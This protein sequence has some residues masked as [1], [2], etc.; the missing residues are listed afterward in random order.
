M[1]ITVEVPGTAEQVWDAIAT[2]NGVSAW[3]MPT[4]LEERVG[5]YVAFHMGETTSEGRI[6]A[7]DQPRRIEYE[8]P[9]WADLTGHD[10]AVVSP[11]VTEFLVEARSGGTCVVRVVSSAFG[12]GADWEREFFADMEQGWRPFFENLRL[13][14]TEFPGQQV[15]SLSVDAQIPDANGSS[16]FAALRRQI[17]ASDVGAPVEVNGVSGRVQRI[18]PGGS[19]GFNELLVRVDTP[20]TGF[21]MFASHDMDGT[22]G[23]VQL[24][25]YL[26]SAGADRYVDQERP[27]WKRW[28]ENLAVTAA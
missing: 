16:L 24:E 13:Y 17:G 1:E 28:L 27:A 2:A 19:S 7:F 20:V 14:L 6:T 26:F 10:D 22:K 4:E 25:G 18:G 9:N 3:F 23:L 8:E 21:L 5:G 15:T 11:L 12:T